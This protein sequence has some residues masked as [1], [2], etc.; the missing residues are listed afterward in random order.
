MATGALIA[1]TVKEPAL[2]L[3]LAFL[4]HLLL[5]S[6][7]HFG[8]NGSGLED[9]FRRP[10][11]KYIIFFDIIGVAIILV[12][13]EPSWLV[14]SAMLLAVSPDF[15]WYIRYYFFEK[16]GIFKTGERMD[17]FSKIHAKVQWFE[18]PIGFF[19]EITLSIVLLIVLYNLS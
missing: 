5:D 8:Y 10:I 6:I 9:F 2:V 16:R 11:V 14:Y 3:P 4:S 7:P 17:L 12:T 15:I 1:I 18:R 13:L 19:V